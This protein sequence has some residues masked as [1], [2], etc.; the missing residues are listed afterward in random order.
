MISSNQK[1]AEASYIGYK[2]NVFTA[3]LLK[4]KTLNITC[5]STCWPRAKVALTAGGHCIFTEQTERREHG[6]GDRLASGIFHLPSFTFA[7]CCNACH[8]VTCERIPVETSPTALGDERRAVQF[9]RRRTH[10][11]IRRASSGGSHTMTPNVLA[12]CTN[13]TDGNGVDFRAFPSRWPAGT[14]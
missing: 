13:P 6:H 9:R 12:R 8:A 4:D 2:K 3:H 11:S 14:L 10:A 1:N 5:M 7:Q